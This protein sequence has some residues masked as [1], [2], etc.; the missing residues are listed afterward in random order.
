[1]KFAFIEKLASKN[2]SL[3]FKVLSLFTAAIVFP[4][5]FFGTIITSIGKNNLKESIF[6]RQQEIVSRLADRINGQLDLHLQL[7]SIRK[8]VNSLPPAQKS[9]FIREI[10]EKGNSF[11]EI[12]ILDPKSREVY[13][14]TKVAKA[15]RRDIPMRSVAFKNS[16]SRVFSAENGKPYVFLKA[17]LKNKYSIVAKFG[18]PQLSS[19]VSEIKIGEFG[20]AFIVDEK[21]NLVA[22]REAERVLAGSDFENLPVVQDFIKNRESSPK[23]WREYFDERGKKVVALYKAIPRLGWAVVTQIPAEEVYQPIASM[24][25]SIFVWTLCWTLV[26]L[27]VGLSFVKKIVDP[28]TLLKV[29]AEKISRGNLDI[30]LNI[31]T[32]D[33]IEDVARDFEKMA[34][35]LKKLESMKEDLTKMVVHDLKS[36]L[37]G[38]M[39]GLDYLDSGLLGAMTDDQAGIVKLAKKSSDNMLALIQNILDIAKMEAGKLDL[40]KEKVN[41]ADLLRSKQKEFGAQAINEEK[42]FSLDVENALPDVVIEKN[43]IER[44][45]NNLISNAIKHTSSKGKI[46]LSANKDEDF[47]KV[48]VSDNGPG[49]P[50]EFKEKIFEKFVQVE[51]D[52]SALRTGAGLG[53]T[54]CKMA[55]E[56]HGGRI[57]VESEVNAGSSFVFTLPLSDA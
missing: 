26:F 40:K 52:K 25:K 13:R 23:R 21:G 20:Q 8:D 50:E 32:G 6:Y 56:A 24:N 27:F 9:R 18:F 28:L 57:W 7:L 51:R 45:I 55:V 38:I 42:E 3:R 33:E 53:L 39:G 12:I 37:S 5:L 17:P 43:I 49:I 14:V 29:G 30:K 34:E 46:L 47:L 11:S 36:P 31:R 10:L 35:D 41:I 15:K 19:W 16:V 48:S 22:H 4:A 1:M 44:V 2:Y 54:F